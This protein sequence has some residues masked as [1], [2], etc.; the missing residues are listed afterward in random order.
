MNQINQ[1]EE[2][3]RDLSDASPVSL[4]V[5]PRI[6]YTHKQSDYLYLFYKKLLKSPDFTISDVSTVGHLKF[7]AHQIFKRNTILHYHWIQYSG[8][9]S[10]LSYFFKLICIYFYLL[11]GGKLVWSIHNKLPPDCSNEWLHFKVRK[12]L[13]KKADRLVVECESAISELSTFFDTSSK[14]FRVWSH[15]GYPPQLMPRAA[16]IEAINHRYQV[17]IKMQDR[18]FMMFGHISSYKQ[19]DKVCE[20]FKDEPIHKILLVVGPVKKGQMQYYK[21]IRRKTK[22]QNNVILI[23]Q[24]IKEECVP[25][26]MNAADYLVFNYREVLTSGG[27]HLAKSYNKTIILP[28]KG[29]LKE[30]D[31]ENLKFFE[32]QDELKKIIREL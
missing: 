9:W 28:R 7:V 31:G 13:A 20:I 16:A 19:I 3:Y 8:F 24:F 32:K 5:A 12:W 25:E 14:K 4:F 17:E 26:F 23:P 27:T 10:G 11:F 22:R 29:C 1:L 6:R 18:I 21:K 2:L 15:P 30:Q